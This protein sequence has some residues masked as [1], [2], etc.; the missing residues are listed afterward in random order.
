MRLKT[1]VL[2][3]LGTL[4]VES[5]LMIGFTYWLRKPS[6]STEPAPT[7]VSSV[8]SLKESELV[9]K[10]KLDNYSKRA[11]DLQKLISLLLTLTTLYA[12]VLAVSAYTGVHLN[13]KQ[14]Q[15]GIDRLDKLVAEHQEI[16][17]ANRDEIPKQKK[18]IEQFNLYSSRTTIASVMSQ[19]PP[20]PDAYAQVQ[21][22]AIDSLLELRNG[23]YA[24]DFIVNQQLSRLYVALKRFKNA[25]DV[26]SAFIKRKRELGERYDEAVVDAYYDRACYQSLRWASPNEDQARLAAGIRRDLLRAFSLN[27]NLRD[28]AKADLEF[29]NVCEERWFRDLVSA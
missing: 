9:L 26:M 27:D 28:Y 23:R 10:E 13:L 21:L 17:K 5:V 22:T 1:V 15:E 18:E 14:A 12:L 4:M 3:L 20:Q 19:F 11:D 25:E 29:K 16:V 24:T 6:V 7:A 8:T 2:V